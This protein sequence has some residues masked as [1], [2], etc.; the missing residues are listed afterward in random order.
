LIEDLQTQI[1]EFDTLKA[2]LSQIKSLLLQ[3]SNRIMKA[4]LSLE[5]TEK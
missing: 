4:S 5:K 3:P 2:E 1:Q